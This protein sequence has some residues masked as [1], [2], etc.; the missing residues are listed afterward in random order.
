MIKHIKS[1]FFNTTLYMYNLSC[2]ILVFLYVLFFAIFNT[3]PPKPHAFIEKKQKS[4]TPNAVI[5]LIVMSSAYLFSSGIFLNIT[6]E[7]F[8][9]IFVGIGRSILDHIIQNTIQMSIDISAHLTNTTLNFDQLTHI[10]GYLT[11]YIRSYDTMFILMMD[12][13]NFFDASNS[14]NFNVLEDMLGRYR[15]AG[16]DLLELYRRIET[17]INISIGDSPISVKD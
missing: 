17:L 12:W 10:H 2:A 9:S 3:T 14:D 5:A 4:S 8:S 11:P 13:V 1:S 7:V 6:S 16:N 15:V